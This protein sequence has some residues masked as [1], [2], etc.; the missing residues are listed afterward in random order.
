[1][2]EWIR[3]TRECTTSELPAAARAA[4]AQHLARYTLRPLLDESLMC[5]VTESTKRKK[6]I[7]APGPPTTTVT[8]II[9]PG[10]LLWANGS[11]DGPQV[12]TS[13]RLADVTVADYRTSPSFKLIPDSGVEISGAFTD[14]AERVTAF[15]PLSENAA[16]TSLKEVAL[17]AVQ[18][19]KK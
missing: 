18:E 3:A 13:A 19:A 14:M 9:T 8:A 17:K 1:M 5:V 7:F 16:G 2:S 12:V 11:G 15:L 4:L 10:W 6:G